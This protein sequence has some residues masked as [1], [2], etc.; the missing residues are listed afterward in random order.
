M[1]AG[2]PSL[3]PH[4]TLMDGCPVTSMGAVFGSISNARWMISMRGAPG[5]GIGVALTGRVGISSRS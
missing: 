2:S 1:P 5:L 3:S 4:G